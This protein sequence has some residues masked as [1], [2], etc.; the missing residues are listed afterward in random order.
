MGSS[1]NEVTYYHCGDCGQILNRCMSEAELL[2]LNFALQNQTNS[3]EYFLNRTKRMK[4]KYPNAGWDSEEISQAERENKVA[5]ITCDDNVMENCKKFVKDKG[6]VSNNELIIYM[7]S[8]GYKKEI[9]EDVARKTTCDDKYKLKLIVEDNVLYYEYYDSSEL[10][11]NRPLHLYNFRIYK[12]YFKDEIEKKEEDINRENKSVEQQILQIVSKYEGWFTGENL[13]KDN[14]SLAIYS[15]QR[16]LSILVML[17]DRGCLERKKINGERYF[18]FIRVIP[19]VK[20][21]K[22]EDMSNEELEEIIC[23]MDLCRIL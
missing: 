6:I 8:L 4:E 19:E 16:I 23:L 1:G 3:D 11:N 21:I 12:N 9:I 14:E 7:Q 2:E 10:I 22:L 13:Q 17:T 15:N 20:A 18:R 5:T